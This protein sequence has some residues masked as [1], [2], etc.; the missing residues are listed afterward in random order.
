[1]KFF[2]LF[3]FFFLVKDPNMAV[4]LLQPVHALILLK[5]LRTWGGTTSSLTKAISQS[6]SCVHLLLHYGAYVNQIHGFH[7]SGLTQT[8]INN[9]G[10]TALVMLALSV[11]CQEL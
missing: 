5:R 8:H 4:A 3:F 2:F 1:M 10:V 9:M 11:K 6:A 7:T